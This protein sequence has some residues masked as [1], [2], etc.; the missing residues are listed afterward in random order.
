MMTTETPSAAAPRPSRRPWIVAL[1]VSLLVFLGAWLL[2]GAL[3]R[4][5]FYGTVV[6]TDTPVYLDFF[7]RIL[8]GGIPYRDV[9]LEYP[10]LALPAFL[11]P[12]LFGVQQGDSDTYTSVFEWL[13]LG[14]G[15]AT[16]AFVFL[17]LRSMAASRTHLILALAILAVSPLLLGP[18]VESRYDLWPVALTAAALAAIVAGHHRTGSAVLVAGA[19][20]KVYPIL[21]LPLLLIYVWRQQGRAEAMRCLAVAGATLLIVLVP[22][23]LIAPEGLAG[24]LLRQLGRPLQV[25]SLA[26]AALFVLNSITGNSAVVGTSSGSQNL[27]GPLADGLASVSSIVQIVAVI[28]VWTWFARG[29]AD[30]VRLVRA[31]AAV[32][33]ADVAFGRV[34]SPQYVIWLAPLVVLVGGRRGLIAGTALVAVLLLTLAYFPSRYFD[35]VRDLD[36]G[37]AWIVLIRDLALVALFGT[38]VLPLQR[39]A[40]VVRTGTLRVDRAARATRPG[41][42]LLV[43]IVGAVLLR[44][45]WLTLPQGSLIFDEAYYVNAARAILGWHIS[46]DA[47]YFGSPIGLDPN[48]EHPPLGKLAIAA[49]MLVFGDNGLGWRLPSVI[50]GVVALLA[51]YAIVRT[52]GRSRWLGVLAVVILALDNLTFVHARI[53]TLDMMAVAAILVGAWL[54]LSHRP[55]LAGT[56]FAIG[57][58]VK[59]TAIF[60]LVAYVAMEAV[61]LIQRARRGEVLTARD[62]REP[63]IAIG[64]AALVGLGG[65]WLLDLRFTEFSNP[66]AHIGHMLSYGV[67]LTGGAQPSGITSNPWDWLVNGG[68]FDYLRVNVNL[69]VN[70]QVVSSYPSVEF[71]AAL[72]PVL[73]GTIWLA[74]PIAIVRAFRQGD[75]LAQWCLIWI[76]A[77][78]LSFFALVAITHRIT[79]FYYILP[80]VPALA[81]L[82]ALMLLRSKLPSFV[83]VAY[84]AALVVGFVAYFPFRQIP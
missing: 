4:S 11:L 79:Y 1:V 68:G 15:L 51:T 58:L 63:A 37:V 75:R 80:T 81:A 8:G 57:C 5:A 31:A 48:S 36:Q 44:L 13:M 84:V 43:I 24:A 33:V 74:V 50:A 67:S 82:T 62:L 17:A 76:A 3:V 20:A 64:A 77:N 72:N 56:A 65:L 26:A 9:P 40:V 69:T 19:M 54:G 7:N 45:V 73:I 21:I 18:V 12:A 39:I 38:L 83:T 46:P 32:V 60:G 30:R 59:I 47:A 28:G 23:A 22:F 25:E 29:P 35:L 27:V 16:I 49:S 6:I 70:G 34:L 61:P 2:V 14:A 10:P 42:V 52:T 53:G 41:R 55:A 66:L 78:Y 71:Q